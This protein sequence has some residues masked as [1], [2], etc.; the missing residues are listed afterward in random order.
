MCAQKK[1]S[2]LSSEE[3]WTL[4]SSLSELYRFYHKASNV[5]LGK[6]FM[7]SWP[8][9]SS[10]Q[11]LGWPESLFIFL[12]KI[13]DFFHFTNNFIELDI[14]SMSAKSCYWLLVGR[15]WEG[16]LLNIF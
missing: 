4:T 1:K 15:G 6:Q 13:R 8:P 9:S 11:V 12:C 10:S 14:L 3:I 16:R 5:H 7:I 2:V